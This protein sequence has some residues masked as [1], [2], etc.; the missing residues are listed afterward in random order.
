MQNRT[1]TETGNDNGRAADSVV[2]ALEAQ[3]VSGKLENRAPLPAERDLMEQFGT[4]RTVI[5]EAISKLSSLGLVET[6]P[7][8]R[9]VVRKP[10]YATVLHACGSVVQHL[11][12]DRKGIK[13]L[14]DS[15]V[16]IERALVRDAALSA[17]K[18]DITD[19]KAALED[20]RKAIPD[21][22]E[23]YRTDVAFHGVLYRIPRNP[24]FPA[25]HEGYTSW[26]SPQWD[27]ML[28]S[29]ERNEVNYI[30]HKAILEAILERDP[31]VAE[32]A[33]TN[34]LKAAWEFVRVTFDWGDE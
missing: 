25:I 13:N 29:P 15:R 1:S 24:I 23:F 7:R 5:R 2:A 32:E 26:L 10:D 12:T 31:A 21:S 18:E 9:P 16:F 27:Q 4:S 14:Y 17:Q 22:H 20:N 3:I 34:H 28:R 6:R 33:L 11:L 8:F 19:L 30:A